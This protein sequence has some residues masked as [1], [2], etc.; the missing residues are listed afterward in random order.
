[1]NRQQKKRA[2]KE[3]WWN[4]GNGYH[5][6]A[7]REYQRIHK[8]NGTYRF[9]LE[10]QPSEVML[11]TRMAYVRHVN[12][13]VYSVNVYYLSG[14]MKGS[15]SVAAGYLRV[16]ENPIKVMRITGLCIAYEKERQR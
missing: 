6:T 11:H 16:E 9:I 4:N 1:M 3:L 15:G 7:I 2:F 13:L 10:D 12:G 8:Y 5:H 14:D